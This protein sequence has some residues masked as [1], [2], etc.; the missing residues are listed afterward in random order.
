M[1]R[2]AKLVT[3][4]IRQ[5]A[6]FLTAF[7]S[8][9]VG[10]SSFS[11]ASP[12]LMEF[13][14]N[15]GSGTN[16]SSSDGK[17]VGTFVGSPTFSTNT[18]SGL[19]GD[20]SLE[21]A[22]GQKVS[23]P[24]PEKILALDPADPSFTIEAWLKFATPT[25][26]AVYLYNNGPG[27]AI[28]A[29]IFTNRTAF[30]TTLGKKDQSSNA[31]IPDDGNWHHVAVIHENAKEFRFYVDG[32]LAD[33]QAYTNGVIFTR[34]NQ[35]F[36]IGGESAATFPYAGFL[37]RLRYHKGVLSADQ[38]DSRAAPAVRLTAGHT[39]VGLAVEDGT[40]DLHIHDESHDVE[41]APDEAVL[42][43]EPE[44]YTTVPNDPRYS[45]LGLPCSGLW[46]LPQTQNTNLLFLGFGAEEIEAGVFQNDPFKLPSNQLPDLGT[47]SFMRL[48]ASE[49]PS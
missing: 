2:D 27:G 21:F 28:S 11:V 18:P 36:Y 13:N 8:I 19:E 5:I 42:V 48:I 17:L 41:Y 40:W 16:V 29:S 35:L 33:T 23:V 7:F 45:F 32:E 46:T 24:D 9:F 37:D 43:V 30:G 20:F 49:L 3:G 47:S 25:A 14:F 1:N 15:E 38:L 10:T 6:R 44:A 26:R 4:R 39:D 31:A 22:A 34:T 12:L